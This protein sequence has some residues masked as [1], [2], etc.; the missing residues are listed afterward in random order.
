M[1]DKIIIDPEVIQHTA[2]KLNSL[3]EK[4]SGCSSAVNG[5]HLDADHGGDVKTEVLTTLASVGTFLTGSTAETLLKSLCRSLVKLSDST[6]AF[7]IKV[8]DVGERFNQCESVLTDMFLQG[9]DGEQANTDSSGNGTGTSLESLTILRDFLK[10]DNNGTMEVND[11]VVCKKNED[12]STSMFIGPTLICTLTSEFTGTEAKLNSFLFG[13]EKDDGNG[14]SDKLTF[15][16]TTKESSFDLNLL[17]FTA[18]KKKER[19]NKLY[20]HHTEDGK[21]IKDDNRLDAD[22]FKTRF[23]VATVGGGISAS[24]SAIDWVHTGTFA[25]GNGTFKEDLKIANVNAYGNWN[26]GLYSVKTDE[27]GNQKRVLTPGMGAEVGVSAT[28][29][30]S[31]TSAEYEIVDG[32]SVGGKTTVTAG[33][34]SAK[35]EVKIGW[36]DGQFNAYGGVS[37]EVIAGEI[38]QELSANIYGVEVKGTGSVNFGLGAHAQAGYHDRK[39]V[40]DVGASVGI[41]ASLSGEINVGGLVDGISDRIDAVKDVVKTGVETIDNFQKTVTEKAQNFASSLADGAE[42]AANQFADGAKA[43][44]KGL[45]RAIWIW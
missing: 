37:A 39:F 29:I 28:L 8:R 40:F 44:G 18:K 9:A 42:K 30:Q 10:F 41:G 27:S 32:I 3:S 13:F 43:I 5:I 15:F 38:S 35:G 17:D 1:S 20:D 2:A 14:N 25:D 23:A 24:K 31:E 45:S 16:N 22:A 33:E 26:A 6:A 7:S 19:K 11:F 21:E 36:I 34:A 12:G 4:L